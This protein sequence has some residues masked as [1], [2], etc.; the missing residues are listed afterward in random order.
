MKKRKPA[1]AAPPSAM[2][3]TVKG[4]VREPPAPV[5]GAMYVTTQGPVPVARLRQADKGGR[6]P[7]P[8]RT[9]ILKHYRECTA[10]GQRNAAKATAHWVGKEVE[11][12]RM[13]ETVHPDTI[14]KWDREEKTRM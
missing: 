3:V 6:H 12:G 5:K 8:H 7:H 11:A 13:T 14:P 2:Y 4:P 1:P 10:R 9:A